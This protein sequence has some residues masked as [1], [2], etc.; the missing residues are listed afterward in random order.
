MGCFFLF[1]IKKRRNGM[2]FLFKIKK[3]KEWD[4][5]FLFK[6]PKS[7]LAIIHKKKVILFLFFQKKNYA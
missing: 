3:K 1:K 5:F 7:F 6:K 4:D 2:F